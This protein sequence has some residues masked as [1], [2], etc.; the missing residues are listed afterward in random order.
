MKKSN[1]LINLEK[2]LENPNFDILHKFKF[3][4]PDIQ[5]TV[6]DKY[7]FQNLSNFIE[8][9]KQSNEE[10]LNNPDTIKNIT[11]ESELENKY[12][13]QYIEMNL[14]L[15]VLDI[16][17]KE[18]VLTNVIN[19][20]N[21]EDDENI[22]IGNSELVKFLLDTNKNGKKKRINKIKK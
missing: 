21:G 6:I 19:T 7:L 14:G 1:D 3:N 9:F 22:D 8:T 2:K 5:N 4:K 15:G 12:K 13:T 11:I 17:P 16:E 20:K 18:N 10:L